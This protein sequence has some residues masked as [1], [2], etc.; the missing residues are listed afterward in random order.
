MRKF[1]K[2]CAWLEGS[3]CIDESECDNLPG[4]CIFAS[5]D[6]CE[7]LDGCNRCFR[8]KKRNCSWHIDGDKERCISSDRCSEEDFQNGVCYDGSESGDSKTTCK[9]IKKGILPQV[10]CPQKDLRVCDS[11][12]TI[13]RDP[14]LNCEFPKCPPRAIVT[15]EDRPKKCPG[16]LSV[17]PDP[18]QNCEYLE[19]PEIPQTNTCPEVAPRSEDCSRTG[20]VP[21]GCTYGDYFI[22]GCDKDSLYCMTSQEYYCEQESDGQWRWQILANGVEYCENEDELPRGTCNPETFGTCSDYSDCYECATS[23]CYWIGGIQTC[24][25]SCDVAP[26]GA[27]CEG[28]YEPAARSEEINGGDRKLRGESDS[29]RGLLSFEDEVSYYCFITAFNDGNNKICADA[30]EGG[31]SSCTSAEIN[32][33]PGYNPDGRPTTCTFFPSTGECKPSGGV[34]YCKGDPIRLP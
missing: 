31:C 6:K 20:K 23:G 25:D 15:C 3:G 18:S 24:V 27:A 10:V 28:N 17:L 5:E 2:G 32:D 19:C 13:F 29:D 12:E 4:E 34:S 11:G 14:D 7:V 16:G 1:E 26:E 9:N 8:N 21:G 33:L 22:A 30:A